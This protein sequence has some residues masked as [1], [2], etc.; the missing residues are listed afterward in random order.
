MIIHGF[1][2]SLERL[3]EKDLEL[4]REKR[5]SQTI[6]QFME[7]REHISPQM[8]L[9]WYTS[10][11]NV[12]NLYYVISY[13]GKKI[14]LINGAKIDWQKMET[15]SG[16]IF[17]WEQDLWQTDVPLM[18]N[19][20]M[21]D[22]ALFL[23]LK[24]SFVKIMNDNTKAIQYNSMLG[25]V[26]YNDKHS[27]ESKI[28][29]LENDNYLEKTEKIRK[30]LYKKYGEVFNIEVDDPEN[31]ITKFLVQKLINVEPQFA[32]RIKLIYHN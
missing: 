29:V 12:Q 18:A 6:S 14:G 10:I 21:M 27:T 16:G 1:G 17:V 8:Q 30:Y 15:A 23:G 9:E 26:I 32:P 25:Y 24:K 2:I 31:E 11:N 7:Y 13:Q 4:V 20:V 3:K 19:L 28:Y 22:L 5:N